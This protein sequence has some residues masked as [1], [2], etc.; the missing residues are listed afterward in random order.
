M[1]MSAAL[2]PGT[3]IAIARS[4]LASAIEPVTVETME[5]TSVVFDDTNPLPIGL[6]SPAKSVWQA[7]CVGLRMKML[8]S[9]VVR[10]PAAVAVVTSTKW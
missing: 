8:A 3:V 10:N 6:A 2:T 9:W 7:D 5:M 1:L 4:A